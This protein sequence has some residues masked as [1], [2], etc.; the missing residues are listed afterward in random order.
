MALLNVN[1]RLAIE[2]GGGAVDVGKAS[3]GAFHSDVARHFFCSSTWFTPAVAI[4]LAL[5]IAMFGTTKVF[6]HLQD[7]RKCRAFRVFDTC[8]RLIGLTA[9]MGPGRCPQTIVGVF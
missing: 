9:R 1:G 2:R 8:L 4:V 5:L 7:A 6:K 3:D